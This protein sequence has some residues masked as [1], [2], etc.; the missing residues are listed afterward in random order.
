MYTHL[1][2][3]KSDGQITGVFGKNYVDNFEVLVG[4]TTLWFFLIIKQKTEELHYFT[5]SRKLTNEAHYSFIY[6]KKCSALNIQA[7]EKLID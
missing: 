7:Q 2:I 6:G 1:Y 5:S 4:K 3:S